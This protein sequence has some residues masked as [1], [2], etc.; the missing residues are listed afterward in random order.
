MVNVE[1]RD[2]LREIAKR[3]QRVDIALDDLDIARS[4]R[5]E[6]IRKAIA[7]GVSMYSI[8]KATGLTGAAI[9]KIRDQEPKR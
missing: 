1:G 4:R 6:T 2:W 9:S 3:N 8:A 7:A 5:N